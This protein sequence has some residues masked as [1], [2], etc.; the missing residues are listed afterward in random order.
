MA[1]NTSTALAGMKPPVSFGKGL[2]GVMVAG[3]PFSTI[4][5]PGTPGAAVAPTPGIGGA[6][7]TS[8]A[9]QLPF[10]NPSGSDHTYLAR[11][12]GQCTQPG[13]L[14][15]CDRLWQNSGITITSTSLQTFTAAAQIPARDANGS[16]AGVGVFAG[17]EVSTV[18]GAGTPTLTFGYT[19]QAGTTGHSAVNTV[20]T[21]AA[22]LA[23]TFYPIGLQAGDT[24]VQKAE[25]L[26]LSATWTSGTIHA[27]LYRELAR[28]E[29]TNA[30]TPNALDLLTGGFTELYNNTVPF[31]IF[32]PSTTTTSNISGNVVYSQVTP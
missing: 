32:L 1:I 13:T 9:G 12:V 4:Y 16:N 2:T 21:V 11:F 17:I 23:G 25:S 24:G 19:N 10:T 5:L 31:L 20:P 14:I 3:R 27:V 15:L 22:S 7:L 6:V 26:T 18:T 29:L 30:N 8:Y 28:L